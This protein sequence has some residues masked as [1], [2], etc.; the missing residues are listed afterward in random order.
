MKT[1]EPHEIARDALRKF[2]ADLPHGAR[3]MYSDPSFPAEPTCASVSGLTMDHRGKAL[4]SRLLRRLNRER[5]EI[6]DGRGFELMD[7]D[8]HRSYVN[9]GTSRAIAGAR[10]AREIA[11]IATGLP[12]LAE[13]ERQRLRTYA[14]GMG[15]VE[16]AMRGAFEPPPVNKP[17]MKLIPKGG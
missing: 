10:R 8:T 12:G 15:V 9:R 11:E 14:G 1:N 5:V 2:L 17:A 3:V 16:A 4:V 6:E 13:S 7:A